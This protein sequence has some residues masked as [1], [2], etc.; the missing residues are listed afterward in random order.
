[1]KNIIY[2]ALLALTVTFAITAYTTSV[3]TDL[4]NGLIRLHV[5]ANSNTET[6]Q[7]IKLNVRD[8]ILKNLPPNLPPDTAAQ[9]CAHIANDT[10]KSGNIPYTAT[11]QFTTAHFPKKQYR[12]LTLPQGN[13]RAVRVILGEGKGENWWCVLYP[14][15]CMADVNG[16]TMSE[17]ARSELKNSLNDETYEI[18]TNKP[19]LKFRVVEIINWLISES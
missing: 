12:E 13:Y 16:E 3:S 2:S 15:V 5:I 19:E 11:A 8:E 18:I 6:D 9:Y 14:P 17:K 7:S 4:K 10:L 1:M